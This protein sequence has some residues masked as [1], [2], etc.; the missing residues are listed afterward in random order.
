M[1]SDVGRVEGILDRKPTGAD[2]PSRRLRN[3][4]ELAYKTRA[5]TDRTLKNQII[6]AITTQETLFSATRFPFDALRNKVIPDL[7][8]RRAELDPTQA[9]SHLVRLG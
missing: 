1:R 9:A 7:I 5:A 2:C 3:V 8:D 4:A 6:D